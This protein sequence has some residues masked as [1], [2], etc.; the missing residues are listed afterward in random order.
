MV[1]RERREGE[2]GRHGGKCKAGLQKFT[3]QKVKFF[4]KIV[5]VS[6]LQRDKSYCK[7]LHALF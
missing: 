4:L 5:F 6:K 7:E 1:G 2:V 3:Q